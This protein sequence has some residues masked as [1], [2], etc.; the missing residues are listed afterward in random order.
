MDANGG[1][2]FNL[3]PSKPYEFEAKITASDINLEAQVN[4]LKPFDLSDLDVKFALSGHDLADVYYLT[5]LALPNTPG[6]HLA[7]TA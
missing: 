6:Y 7:A 5:G 2:L 1:P 4:V 3:E